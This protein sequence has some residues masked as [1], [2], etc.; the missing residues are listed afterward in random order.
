MKGYSEE[1]FFVRKVQNNPQNKTVEFKKNTWYNFF[2]EEYFSK[3]N[4]L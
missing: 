4:A 1:D 3:E 2:I